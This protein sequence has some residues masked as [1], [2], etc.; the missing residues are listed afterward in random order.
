MDMT[1]TTHVPVERTL[2]EN[3]V[4]NAQKDFSAKTDIHAL[5]TQLTTSSEESRV[6]EMT[7]FRALADVHV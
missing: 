1:P 5:E 2:K 7:A 6:S 3:T 4:T